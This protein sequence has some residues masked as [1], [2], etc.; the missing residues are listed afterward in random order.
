[1][2]LPI[3]SESD[4]SISELDLR[5]RFS[6]GLLKINLLDLL[7]LSDFLRWGVVDLFS[8]MLISLQEMVSSYIPLMF[9]M[10]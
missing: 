10:V 9:S 1:M 3:Y 4:T 6:R 8:E 2:D 5:L 7:V